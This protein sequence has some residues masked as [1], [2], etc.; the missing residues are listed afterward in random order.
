MSNQLPPKDWNTSIFI[1][2]G[3]IHEVSLLQFFEE[4]RKS[5]I[6]KP[7]SFRSEVD[8]RVKRAEVETIDQERARLCRELS[9]LISLS[10]YDIA[11]EIIERDI[12]AQDSFKTIEERRR[13]RNYSLYRVAADIF[14]VAYFDEFSERGI[15]E[16]SHLLANFKS[17]L[18][19]YPITPIEIHCHR[20]SFSPLESILRKFS[21]DHFPLYSGSNHQTIEQLIRELKK[22]FDSNTSY[23]PNDT[24][25]KCTLDATN[26]DASKE[27]AKGRVAPYKYNDRPLSEFRS[28][29]THEIRNFLNAETG[30]QSKQI[31][32]PLRVP[33]QHEAT[34]LSKLVSEIIRP[35]VRASIVKRQRKDKLGLKKNEIELLTTRA[36]EL[37]QI[38]LGNFLATF[39]SSTTEQATLQNILFELKQAIFKHPKTG[40]D[41]NLKTA[42]DRYSAVEFRVRESAH[43]SDLAELTSNFFPNPETDRDYTRLMEVIWHELLEALYRLFEIAFDP[44]S[45]SKPSF[46]RKEIEYN[47]S[48]IYSRSTGEAI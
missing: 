18:Y 40:P 44:T 42:V 24:A 37:F 19:I 13:H 39:S 27:P 10:L 17:H 43:S 23:A 7:G 8:Y 16:L 31:L 11:E 21:Q 3:P 33:I 30:D 45:F 29:T 5:F 41:S 34:E 26:G 22:Y 20:K 2:D 32:I 28:S 38:H 36:C 14:A 9:N 47:K 1:G 35:D 6:M 12:R 46:R 48:V 4:I 15:E 25:L